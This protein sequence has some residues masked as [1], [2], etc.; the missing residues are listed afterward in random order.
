MSDEYL[1][2][3]ALDMFTKIYCKN[4][5]CSDLVFRCGECEF[6]IE[7]DKC[8]IKTFKCKHCPDYKDFGCMGDL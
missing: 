3:M 6:K 5:G 4:N 7:R 2:T 8:L 1:A